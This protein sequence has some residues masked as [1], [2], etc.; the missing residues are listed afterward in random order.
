MKSF[1]IE[2]VLQFL[3]WGKNLFFQIRTGFSFPP[4]SLQAGFLYI[5]WRR[6]DGLRNARAT[7]VLYNR[8]RR[9]TSQKKAVTLPRRTV[10]PRYKTVLEEYGGHQPSSRKKCHHHHPQSHLLW[11]QRC[12]EPAGSHLPTRPSQKTLWVMSAR[13][14]RK[15]AVE[16]TPRGMHRR[17]GQSR[18]CRES[19]K[20]G[21]H[22]PGR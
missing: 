17:I 9:H 12:S 5:K 15:G 3:I 13:R 7:T 11:G 1:T 16:H 2:M 19:G 20:R 8:K 14:G 18:G 21:E 4:Q 10:P 6:H 22:L